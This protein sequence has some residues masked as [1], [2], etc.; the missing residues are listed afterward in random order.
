MLYC[1]AGYFLKIPFLESYLLAVV[2]LTLAVSLG[3]RSTVL[4]LFCSKIQTET[5]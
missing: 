3:M 5:P 1:I 2:A 4:H